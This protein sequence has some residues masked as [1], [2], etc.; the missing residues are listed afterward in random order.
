MTR[1]AHA[2]RIRRSPRLGLERL[3]DRTVPSFL[4][5]VHYEVGSPPSRPYWTELSDLDRDGALDVVSANFLD[6][7]VSVL[8]N[9]GDGTLT[10]ADAFAVGGAPAGVVA[11]DF[12]RDGWPDLA[13]ADS[14][15]DTV[16]V[17]LNRGGRD[18]GLS[19]S[20]YVGFRPSW[21]DAADVNRDGDT[22]LIASNLDGANVTVRLGRG[23]GRFGKPTQLTVGS[24]PRAGAVADLDRD[25]ALDLVVPNSLTN[26]ISVLRNNGNGT[27]APAVPYA[28]GRPDGNPAHV[29]VGDLDLD[30][31]L[32]LAVANY[33]SAGG[34][35]L[36]FNNGDGTFAAANYL[37]MAGGTD[38]V[39]SADFNLDGVPDLAAANDF[40]DNVTVRLNLL[41]GFGEATSYATQT[42]PGGLDVG[43]LN[44]DLSPDLTAANALSH[45]VSVLLNDAGW[46]SPFGAG[47]W[48]LRPAGDKGAGPVP[49]PAGGGACPRRTDERQGRSPRDQPHGAAPPHR[50]LARR[51]AP[52]LADCFAAPTISLH[53][54]FMGAR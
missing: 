17:L 16:T 2:S 1:S 50:A 11:A 14:A 31:E 49:V 30:G 37:S 13:T 45:S 53:E 15:W 52:H 43:D 23:N 33:T 40:S 29:A 32:D 7:T 18:F 39:V 21:V 6:N 5:A 25:G 46:D 27:F 34:V 51:A 41:V 47:A 54:G 26:D 12:N 10:D 9:S 24:G 36:F 19:D 20:F 44:G 38:T 28:T 4:P 48:L 35:F 22:D 42:A 8:W 3:E